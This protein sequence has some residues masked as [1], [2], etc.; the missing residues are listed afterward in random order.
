M[1]NCT[2][3]SVISNSGKVLDFSI[4]GTHQQHQN[5]I[6]TTTQSAT[7]HTL[8]RYAKLQKDHRAKNNYR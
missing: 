7:T 4:C 5:L 8:D 3:Q 1:K 6:R 2:Q